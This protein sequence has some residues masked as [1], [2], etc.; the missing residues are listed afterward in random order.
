M[1]SQVVVDFFHLWATVVWIGALFLTMLAVIPSAKKRLQPPAV[2]A[3]LDSFMRRSR[4]VGYVCII[5]LVV[6]GILLTFMEKSPRSLWR[7][8]ML[9]KHSAIAGL[10]IGTVYLH[11][12]MMPKI[13]RL[14]SDPASKLT[15][16][17]KLEQKQRFLFV[18]IFILGVL[19]LFLSTLTEAM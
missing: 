17:E 8:I 13:T 19:I 12:F 18:I 9:I 3:F 10:V 5:A 7:E 4:L 6:S 2:R 15:E 1:W 11:E 16:V 14:S